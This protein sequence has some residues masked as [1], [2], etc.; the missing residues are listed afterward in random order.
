MYE[1]SS[2]SFSSSYFFPPALDCPIQVI[3]L[4]RRKIGSGHFTEALM[5]DALHGR[6]GALTELFRSSLMGITDALVSWGGDGGPVLC[7]ENAGQALIR[8]F[9]FLTGTLK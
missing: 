6:A 2:L 3:T 7:S 5:A 1:C 9:L 8:R 4:F